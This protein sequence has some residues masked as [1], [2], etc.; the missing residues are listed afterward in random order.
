MKQNGDIT[1]SS[2]IS[3]PLAITLLTAAVG[4][5]GMFASIK[6]DLTELRRHVTIDWTLRDMVMWTTHFNR[7]NGTNLIVPDP[8]NIWRK[9]NP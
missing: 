7:Q 6:A 4:I 5:S 8:D 2:K 1:T 3:L 9:N